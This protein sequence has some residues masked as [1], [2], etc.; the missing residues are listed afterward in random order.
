V[1]LLMGLAAAP[2][3]MAAAESPNGLTPGDCRASSTLHSIGLE[4]D[5]TGDANHNAVCTVRY[6]PAGGADWKAAMNLFRIDCCYQ[7]GEHKS[8]RAYNMMAGSILFLAPGAAYDVRMELSD[9]DGGRHV[10]DLAVRTRPEPRLPTGGRTLHVAPGPGGGDGSEGRP[11]A[12]LG[13][14][15]SAAA[16]GDRVLL[17]Q[18]DYGTFAFSRP[19]EPGR[20][21]VFAA[22]G[23]GDA[24][25]RH[26]TVAA[27]HVWL[28]GL[29]FQRGEASDNG[30]TAEG[31]AAEVVVRHCRFTGFHYS[32]TLTP[33]CRDWFIADN[34]IVGDKADANVS[35][36][37]G[38]GVELNHGSGHVVAHNRISRVADGISYALRN[39]D[40]YGNDIRDVTDDGIEPDYGYANIR[41]WGNRIHGAFNH[42]LS[43][44]P[45]F[46]GPWY[47]VR[48]EVSA[49][50]QVLKPN[51]ADR[52]VL[53]SNTLVG[54]GR[55]A[56]G[57]ANLLLKSFS[58]NN[59]WILAPDPAGRDTLYAWSGTGPAASAYTMPAQARPDW[60]TDVDYD[61]FD[62]DAAPAPFL[63]RLEARAPQPFGDL[64]SFAEALGIEKHAV[65]VRREAV[66]EVPDVRAYT[67]EPFSPR[68]LTL[69]AGCNAIDAG[70]AVPN[71]CDD[72]VGRAP[73]LGA[74]EFGKPPP[75]YGPRP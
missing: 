75:L 35:E 64:A 47:L 54:L 57:R 52:F 2:H 22:A 60:R 67:Q 15:Q 7:Y 4:W 50:R 56:Q 10:R 12:D 21:L 16:P 73:D 43:F 39:C 11:F 9:P 30:L 28:E 70:Q 61:G 42:A 5:L 20:P 33:A 18:G 46:C 48:N 3:G 19:G 25:L 36:M 45:Q 6:R 31:A 27:S 71:V 32:I 37:S 58:R 8:D 23:N 53:V 59:L 34:V 44:Q 63:W 66:F 40:L 13:A 74:Y 38:E 51:M 62:W 69:R 1:T 24:V 55:E 17:H 29:V 49:R 14:A 72:F 26:A 41:I 65:R 68:R